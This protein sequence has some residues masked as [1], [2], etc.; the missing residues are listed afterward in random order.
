MGKGPRSKID[1]YDLGEKVMRLADEGLTIR[2][3]TEKLLA[4][5]NI[6]S[7][8]GVSHQAVGTWIAKQ[9]KLTKAMDDGFD[10]KRLDRLIAFLEDRLKEDNLE[11]PPTLESQVRGALAIGKL[12]ELKLKF[13]VRETGD[14]KEGASMNLNDLL[15]GMEED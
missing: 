6:P 12:V 13:D 4:D 9:R 7:G 15:S 10:I 8:V 14:K 3:I 2:K 1:K 11:K 5:G